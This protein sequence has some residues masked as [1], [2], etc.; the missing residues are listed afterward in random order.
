VTCR[1]ASCSTG[2]R[3]VERIEL[4]AADDRTLP[5]QSAFTGVN[6]QGQITGKAAKDG[7]GFYGFILD[8]DRQFHRIEF[9]GA[10]A[11]YANK[12]DERGRIAGVGDPGAFGYLL[13]DG[14]STQI[15]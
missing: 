8:R 3:V 11:T 2:G 14:R 9:P 1:S 7:E 4:P 5:G 10:L 6:T 13:E 15:A 12:I